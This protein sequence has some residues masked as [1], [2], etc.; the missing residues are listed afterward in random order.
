MFAHLSVA[1]R[2]DLLLLVYVAVDHTSSEVCL[3]CIRDGN[4]SD[5]AFEDGQD[6][7]VSQ[8]ESKQYAS[9]DLDHTLDIS[10]ALFGLMVV[11]QTGLTR[12]R[13]V[14]EFAL[15]FN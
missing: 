4:Q 5:S 8:Q 3:L 2:G 13:S 12:Q 7:V 6:E 15:A 10:R 1:T 11:H 9:K 14:R